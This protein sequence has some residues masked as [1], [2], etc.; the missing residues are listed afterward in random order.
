VAQRLV[1]FPLLRRILLIRVIGQ[2]NLNDVA[3]P[4][5][6][7]GNHVSLLDGPAVLMSLPEPVRRR[8][9][10]AALAGFY[11]PLA[12]NPLVR[13]GQWE[14]FDLIA[15]FFNVYPVPRAGGFRPSLQ[16]SGWL[17]D[18]GWNLLVLPEGTRSWTGEMGPFREGI[19]LLAAELK[20]PVIP[21]RIHGTVAILP[22]GALIPKP[23]PVTVTFGKPLSFPTE[24]YWQITREVE[25][26]VAALAPLDGVSQP[27]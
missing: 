25:R 16:Y 24:A 2:E 8:L 6:L 9:A 11:Y 18:H 7:A 1:I 17:V 4:F 23:G 3:G 12:S 13:T 21:F 26:A 10:I 5:I 15:F 27:M 22:R 20:I 19:G 14:L